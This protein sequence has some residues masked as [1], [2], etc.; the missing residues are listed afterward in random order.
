MESMM[1]SWRRKSGKKMVR[2]QL[3]GMQYHLVFSVINMLMK[4][5]L[6]LPI[7][8][9][10]IILLI[11]LCGCRKKTDTKEQRSFYMGV[12]PWPADF[13][14]SA[15]DDAY[16]FIN[17][18]CDFVSHHFDEGIPYEE[19]FNNLEFPQQLR[20][21]VAA[22]KQKTAIG[23]KI[24]LS[25]AAL[26]LTRHQKADYYS[27]SDQLSQTTKDSWQALP[28]NDAKVVTAYTSYM[29]WL[30]DQFH[31]AFVNYGVESNDINW[32]P[33][34]F[35]LYK[36]FLSKVYANLKTKYPGL[37][38]FVS[39]MVNEEAVALTQAS[40]LLPYTDYISLSAYPYTSASST[41]DGNTDP[42]K[43][44]ADY[45]TRFINLDASKPFGFAETGFI[46]QPLAI[47]AYS[48]NKQG[49]SAW[50]RD[51]LDLILHLCNDRKAKFLIWFCYADY[52]AG[53]ERLRSLG[54]YQDLF[55]LWQDI[56]FKDENN[57][58]RPSYYLWLEWMNKELK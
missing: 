45:F 11:G 31:P 56:G 47:A 48:L 54:L 12:T 42:K 52:D 22:R 53:N 4:N 33:A 16:S 15:V 26:N 49:S 35:V 14:P 46:A 44:P 18:H 32:M 39:F 25:V 55:G 19:A 6:R 30:I 41:A 29:S 23:K 51:Y 34:Q 28:V 21:D 10:C 17:A 8:F 58:L 38:F 1:K 40:Q 43:F 13:T 3:N 20:D 27:H 57:S 7:V 36:D 50:Q 5:C 24:F 9:A 2:P 37:P